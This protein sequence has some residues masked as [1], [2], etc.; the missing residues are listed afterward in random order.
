[1]QRTTSYNNRGYVKYIT[2]YLGSIIYNTTGLTISRRC[3]AV[4]NSC[5]DMLV[6][7]RND[8]TPKFILAKIVIKIILNKLTAYE[9]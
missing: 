3:M 9:M 8:V 4:V 2:V 5:F 7:S 1:M 6:K